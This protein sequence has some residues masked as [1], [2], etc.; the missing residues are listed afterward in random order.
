MRGTRG[1]FVS[2]LAIPENLLRMEVNGYRAFVRAGTSDH[3]VVQEICKENE[4]RMLNISPSDIVMDAGMN[5]GMFTVW[6]ARQGAK[7]VH[8][9]EPSKQNYKL[10][11]MNIKLNGC[12]RPGIVTNERAL[13]GTGDMMRDFSMNQRKNKGAHSLVAKKGRATVVVRCVNFQSELQRV[14]PSVIK[15]DIEG[16]EYECLLA[17]DDFGGV[18]ELIIEYH[19]DHLNDIK[20]RSKYERLVAH[21]RRFFSE[22]GYKAETKKIWATPLFCVR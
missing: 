13:V 14:R 7:E 3:Y 22:V 5:I 4:Y 2:D 16:G 8:S 10:A 21:L 18:R 12:D 1:G 19:H 17:T 6:A 11:L 9:Y 20:T 15:M